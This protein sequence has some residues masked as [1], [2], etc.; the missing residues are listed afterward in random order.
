MASV[1]ILI[2]FGGAVLAAAIMYSVVCLKL[3]T[4]LLMVCSLPIN[5]AGVAETEI[6]SFQDVWQT[7][8]P[9]SQTNT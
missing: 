6:C 8:S 7:P 9:R 3:A 2:R 4:P 1:I 5:L